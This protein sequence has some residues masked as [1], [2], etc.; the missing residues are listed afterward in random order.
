MVRLAC[1]D[2]LIAAFGQLNSDFEIPTMDATPAAP[3]PETTDRVAQAVLR[4]DPANTYAQMTFETRN[5]FVDMYGLSGH[6]L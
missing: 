5:Q 2:A 3:V 4:T 6:F 1:L